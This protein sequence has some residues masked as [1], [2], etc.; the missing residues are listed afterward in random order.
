[1][2]NITTLVNVYVDLVVFTRIVGT[3]YIRALTNNDETIQ[4]SLGQKVAQI[5]FAF[6]WHGISCLICTE[7][8]MFP[9]K[10]TVKNKHNF[11]SALVAA[12]LSQVLV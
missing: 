8:K 1:M 11:A 3:S 5:R 12:E 10:Y 4:S 7:K 2:Y 6:S 9:K